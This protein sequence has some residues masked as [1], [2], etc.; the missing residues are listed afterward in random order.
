MEGKLSNAKVPCI[1]CDEAQDF[2]SN[3]LSLIIRSL[4]FSE[5]I[6]GGEEIKFLPLVFA[7]DPL[8]TINPTGFKWE[9]VQTM[10]YNK[11]KEILHPK[12]QTP[13]QI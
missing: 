3:E 13:I 1:F 11:I 4:L 7:G 10:F 9:N 8:Q 5:R 12:D 6:L 2:T